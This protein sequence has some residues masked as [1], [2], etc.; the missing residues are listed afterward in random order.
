MTSAAERNGPTPEEV[1]DPLAPRDGSAA[2]GSAPAEPGDTAH[3]STAPGARG[4][5]PAPGD[6]A[7][8]PAAG[9]T[10]V[11]V[12]A[13]AREN[14]AGPARENG[15]GPGAAL[16]LAEGTGPA[17]EGEPRTSSRRAPAG[18]GRHAAPEVWP[19]AATPLGA[20]YRV[21]PDGVAGTNFA[22]WA[23]G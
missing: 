1:A 9:T 8:G 18:D 10:A 12:P 5:R 22:V 20:R 6:H 15:A 23:G 21:G 2:N 3:G 16:G 4:A 7:P 14:G 11:R 13:P 19:G 17:G